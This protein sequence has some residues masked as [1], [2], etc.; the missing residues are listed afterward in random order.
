MDMGF[1]MM[2]MVDLTV[3]VPLYFETLTEHDIQKERGEQG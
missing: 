3:F 2:A 1:W